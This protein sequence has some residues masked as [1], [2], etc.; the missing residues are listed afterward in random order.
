MIHKIDNKW[1]TEDI[2]INVRN[3]LWDDVR[4][5]FQNTILPDVKDVYW[6]NLINIRFNVNNDIRRNTN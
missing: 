5:N 6:S 2:M 4:L 3:V 1:M